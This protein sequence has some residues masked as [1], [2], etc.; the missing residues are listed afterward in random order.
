MHGARDKMHATL[1][2]MLH[3]IIDIC[4][5][6]VGLCKYKNSMFCLISVQSCY[7]SFYLSEFHMSDGI[8]L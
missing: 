4:V 7:P 8:M 1:H 3:K 6:E 5:V 2:A